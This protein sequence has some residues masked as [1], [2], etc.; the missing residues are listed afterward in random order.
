M[1]NQFLR[2]IAAGLVG[3]VLA[4]VACGVAAVA[5]A[6]AIYA[7]LR[8]T[9]SAAASAAIDA[10]VFAVIAGLIALILPRLVRGPRRKTAAASRIDPDT[11]R[12]ATDAGLAVLTAITEM[13]RGSR[14]R[15][16]KETAPDRPSRRRR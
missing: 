15:K 13:A 12:L 4:A 11:A 9:L 1:L 7:V 5:V 8:L 6:Y 3:A 14:R 2:R 10:G 16:A